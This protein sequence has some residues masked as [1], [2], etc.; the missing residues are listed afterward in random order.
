MT[1]DFEKA[2]KQD[3]GKGV[4]SASQ[5]QDVTADQKFGP[6]NRKPPRDILVRRH[7]I[8]AEVY[9]QKEVEVERIIEE[10]LRSD[11]EEE[12]ESPKERKRLMRTGPLPCFTTLAKRMRL[13][14]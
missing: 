2:A 14:K 10:G 1:R 12:V 9:A 13:I 5:D 8:P 3:K 7:G 4:T 11:A 6:P